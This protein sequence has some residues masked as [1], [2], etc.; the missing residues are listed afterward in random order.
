MNYIIYLSEK[1]ASAYNKNKAINI[2][3]QC[4]QW[5]G[6]IPITRPKRQTSKSDK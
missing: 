2:I 3:F 6:D 1:I 4:N 5:T